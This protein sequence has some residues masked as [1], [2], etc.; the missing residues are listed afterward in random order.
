[1]KTYHLESVVNEHGE[2][3]LPDEMKNLRKHR[4]KLIIVDL[5]AESSEPSDF[6]DCITKKFSDIG[7]TDLDIAEVYRTRE[8]IDARRIVC[9]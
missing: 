8:N 7:E 3:V 5:E 6:L 4:V 1:M 2:I 9:D